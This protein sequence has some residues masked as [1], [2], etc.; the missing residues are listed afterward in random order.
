MLP[1]TNYILITI[2]VLI[3]MYNAYVKLSSNP[4]AIQ[5][6]KGLQLEPYGRIILGATELL[7]AM[8]L[9][10]PGT[11]KYGSILATLLMSG[12]IL[13][14]LTLIGIA[15]GGN[16]NFFS[17]GIIAFFCSVVLVWISYQKAGI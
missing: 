8:L 17:M 12:V 11:Q 14:H 2:V 4:G 16:Y 1:I 3:L 13:I 7:A 10:F 9:I 6:F 5:L 15:L